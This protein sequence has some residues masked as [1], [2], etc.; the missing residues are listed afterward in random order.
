M[1]RTMEGL[2]R[3]HSLLFELSKEPGLRFLDPG[4]HPLVLDALALATELRR[5][6]GILEAK[7]VLP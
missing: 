7:G 2:I 3:L 1:S 4:C 6:M 5:R